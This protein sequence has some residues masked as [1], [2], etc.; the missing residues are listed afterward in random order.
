MATTPAQEYRKRRLNLSHL[1]VIAAVVS[2]LV[3]VV[4]AAR[5]LRGPT[6]GG[7]VRLGTAYGEPELELYVGDRLIALNQGM[8]AWEEILGLDGGKRTGIPLPA[9]APSVPDDPAQIASLT[10]ADAERLAGDGASV[11]SVAAGNPPWSSYHGRHEFAKKEILLRRADGTLDH[12]FCLDTRLTDLY[13]NAH[14]LL[15]PIRVRPREGSTGRLFTSEAR[16]GGGGRFDSF[17]HRVTPEW[18]FKSAEP[19]PE[20]AAEIAEHG[21]WTPQHSPSERR[22]PDDRP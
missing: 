21:L 4:M 14:R 10:Q 17:L 6:V 22:S 12:L 18:N 7:G 16:S 9:D 13:G 2:L 11:V 3:L 5:T 8:V 1:V 20:L 15:V 19:P